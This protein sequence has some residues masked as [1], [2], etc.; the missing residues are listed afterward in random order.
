MEAEKVGV[1]F[2]SVMVLPIVLP[3][4]SIQHSIFSSLLNLIVMCRSL[5]SVFFSEKVTVL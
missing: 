3:E 4:M 1:K 5:R 2:H